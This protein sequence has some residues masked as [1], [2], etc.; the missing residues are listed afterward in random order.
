MYL[1]RFLYRYDR[2]LEANEITHDRSVSENNHVPGS[3]CTKCVCLYAYDMHGA[4]IT[5]GPVVSLV[6]RFICKRQ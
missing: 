3:K 4:F 6:S 5:T 1:T 2:D